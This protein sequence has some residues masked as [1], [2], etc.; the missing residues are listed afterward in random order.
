M[1]KRKQIVWVGDSAFKFLTSTD[2]SVLELYD[3]YLL[4]YERTDTVDLSFCQKAGISYTFL[5]EFYLLGERQYLVDHL[6]L[7]VSEYLKDKTKAFPEG[8]FVGDAS[9]ILFQA[10]V[11]ACFDGQV[12]GN[13]AEMEKII[14]ILEERQPNLHQFSFMVRRD[15]LFLSPALRFGDVLEEVEASKQHA[16]NAL[17]AV[18]VAEDDLPDLNRFLRHYTEGAEKAVTMDE[19]IKLIRGDKDQTIV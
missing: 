14:N 18:L 12:I 5:D 7:P 3:N 16:M 13:A 2:K 9:E 11:D 1:K 4:L 19:R 15:V 6:K 8:L 10:I 17:E